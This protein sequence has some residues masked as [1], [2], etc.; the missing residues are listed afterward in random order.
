MSDTD[1]TGLEI[2][3]PA[4][5]RDVVEMRE[6]IVVLA[7]APAAWMVQLLFGFASTSYL[8]RPGDPASMPGWLG[9]SLLG[10]NL[11]ALLASVGALILALR[12]AHDTAHEHRG[13]SGGILEAGEGRT[14]FLASWGALVSTV[15]IVAIL[16]NSLSL[17]L[18]PL[19]RA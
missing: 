5:A 13:R 4:P 2:G 14:R 11:A 3:H 16:A 15:F 18:V 8:C 1:H 19:C 9:P 7:A 17:L 6:V 10:L 12:L